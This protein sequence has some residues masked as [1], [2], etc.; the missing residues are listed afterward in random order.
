MQGHG[1]LA[2][3]VASLSGVSHR[4][5]WLPVYRFLKTWIAVGLIWHAGLAQISSSDSQ[6]VGPSLPA[7]AGTIS[8]RWRGPSFA[9]GLHLDEPLGA[10]ATPVMTGGH[11]FCVVSVP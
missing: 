6:V 3:V 2:A 4:W 7:W 5:A 11:V 10:D 1:Q 8:L 9:M